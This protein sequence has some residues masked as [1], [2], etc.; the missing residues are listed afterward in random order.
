MAT[1]KVAIQ[2]KVD[3]ELYEAIYRDAKEKGMSLSQYIATALKA[4]TEEK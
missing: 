3:P 4:A 2:T 1:A